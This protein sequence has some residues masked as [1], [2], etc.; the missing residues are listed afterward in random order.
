MVITGRKPRNERLVNIM[1]VIARKRKESK[2][3]VLDNAENL[4]RAMIRLR[5][6]N[7]GIH[8]IFEPVRQPYRIAGKERNSQQYFLFL[9]DR[10]NKI[11]EMT[12]RLIFLINQANSIYPTTL[13]ELEKRRD[14]QNDAIGCCTFILNQMQTINDIYDIDLNLFCECLD[15]LDEQ[16]RLLKRWRQSDNKIRHK[17]EGDR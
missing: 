4:K 16:L 5:Q 14:I 10:A 6:E 9:K 3:K 17:L 12:D 1:S 7:Y 15:L 2:F 8:D 13:H 11:S